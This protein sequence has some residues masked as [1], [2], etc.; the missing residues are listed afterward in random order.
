MDLYNK[1]ILLIEDDQ[2][3]FALIKMMLKPYD[4]NLDLENDGEKGLKT[5]LNNDYDL[6]LLDIMLPK[7][8]GWEI[9]RQLKE[10]DKNT[11][12]I[13]LTAKAEETD[14]VLGLELG[15]DDYV[16]KPFSP[17]LL[18]A[19]IK[20]VLR[21][22]ENAENISRNKFVDEKIGLKIDPDNYTISVYDKN[23]DLTPKEF[24]LLCFLA[25][26]E[27]QVFK[28]EQLLD[29]VWGIDNYSETRT[30]DEHIKRIRQ[31]LSK[32]GL[33]ESPLKTVWGVGYKYSIG[34]DE[35]EI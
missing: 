30:I 14:K 12:I 10:A 23:V 28:R 17:S 18:V 26:N 21:R 9:C 2:H 31:K 4:I 34:E 13:M 1:N 25:Q 5:A 11:P 33:K 32:A 35:N 16:T 24:E 19:R 6:V 7:K 27:G 22:F 29:H 8:D 15:A 20:A 3:I